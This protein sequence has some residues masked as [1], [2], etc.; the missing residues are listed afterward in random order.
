L[1]DQRQRPV[2]DDLFELIF[3]RTSTGDIGGAGF[4]RNMVPPVPA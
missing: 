1:V 3:C 2:G 4:R